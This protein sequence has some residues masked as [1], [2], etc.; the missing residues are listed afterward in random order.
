MVSKVN[1]PKRLLLASYGHFLVVGMENKIPLATL[2][3][4]SVECGKH[5]TLSSTLLPVEQ[6][7]LTISI[8][9]SCLQEKTCLKI[10]IK[11]KVE[12]NEF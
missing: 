11:S 3:H 10:V 7:T 4:S 6:T 12:V 5:S 8:K 1:I 9:Y 2:L